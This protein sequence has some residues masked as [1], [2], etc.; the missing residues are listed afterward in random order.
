MLRILVP[1]DGSSNSL[2]AVR[3]VVN[4]FMKNT[5]LEIHLLNVQA[6]FSQYIAR[7]VSRKDRDAFHRDQAEQALLPGR[8]MLDRFGVPY[9]VHMELGQK[10]Y[11]IIDAARRLRCDHIVMSTARKSSL[12]RMVENSTTN[13]VIELTTVPVKIIAGDAPS[14]V[15]RYGIPAGVGTALASLFLAAA[16]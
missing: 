16:N 13:K 9:H 15:E 7:F 1:V 8:Q 6:P 3:H 11:V 14:K 12:I 4:E 10:A 5:A 2:H